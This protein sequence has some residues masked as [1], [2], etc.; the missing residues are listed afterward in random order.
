MSK[1]VIL[2]FNR[3][4]WM[5]DGDEFKAEVE[6]ILE[7]KP[8]KNLTEDEVITT[9]RLLELEDGRLRLISVGCVS[10]SLTPVTIQRYRNLKYRYYD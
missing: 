10:S 2:P 4:V 9:L 7:A 5:A 8:V 1:I 3:E 6:R